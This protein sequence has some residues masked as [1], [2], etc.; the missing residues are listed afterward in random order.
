MTT[1]AQFL[2]ATGQTA[3]KHALACVRDDDRSESSTNPFIALCDSAVDGR[4][5][6][7]TRGFDKGDRIGLY[8]EANGL[9]AP[10]ARWCN[11][12]DTPTARGELDEYGNIV[13]VARATLYGRRPV[14]RQ[15][16]GTS[17]VATVMVAADEIT[18]DY[19]QIH[20]LFSQE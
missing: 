18:V 4:G 13:L 8:A 5:A 10:L 2:I 1:Y 16:P 15:V 19:L 6:V 7:P 3:E 11:H 12:S 9:R 20:R 17:R 14:Q